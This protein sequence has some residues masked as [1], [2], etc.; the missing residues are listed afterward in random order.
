MGC[1]GRAP[2]CI[3]RASRLRHIAVHAPALDAIMWRW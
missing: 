1:A 2:A 3:G